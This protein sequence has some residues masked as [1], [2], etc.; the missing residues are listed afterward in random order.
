VDVGI[1]SPSREKVKAEKG[2]T[3]LGTVARENAAHWFW[4]DRGCPQPQH[5]EAKRTF[6]FLADARY[7]MAAAARRAAVRGAVD[8]RDGLINFEKR[9]ISTISG[10]DARWNVA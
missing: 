1:R 9:Q 6:E 2:W 8:H 7:L 4:A 3:V 5:A 10:L